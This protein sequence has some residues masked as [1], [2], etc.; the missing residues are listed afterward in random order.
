MKLIVGLGNPGKQYKNTRH[1]IGYLML[2]ELAKR[3]NVK[4]SKKMKFKGQ[5]IQTIIKNEQVIL[6]KPI[7]FMNLS[8]QSVQL[9]KKFYNIN[10]EDI[11]VIYDDLDLPT[12]KIRFKQKG[13]SGGHKGIK[14][15]ISCINSQDFHRLKIGI[16]RDDNIPVVDYVVG[17]FTKDQIDN[18]AKV[19][20]IS[21]DALDNWI[22]NEITF[23][24]NKYN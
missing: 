17:K 4:F 7:T 24:M 10:D 1:N 14:S 5:F 8:G 11:L 16:D 20:D 9:V 3:E 15:I 13:S 19:I 21:L 6:L 22:S 12:G 2:D 23:V 18:I